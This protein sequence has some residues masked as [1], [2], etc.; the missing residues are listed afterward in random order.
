MNWIFLSNF[1]LNKLIYYIVIVETCI[2]DIKNE[3][4]DVQQN[5]IPV[6]GEEMPASNIKLVADY[7]EDVKSD[8]KN[9]E[10]DFVPIEKLKQLGKDI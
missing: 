6:K 8:V 5:V 10:S 9:V 7:D 4:K 3:N 2:Q 1:V